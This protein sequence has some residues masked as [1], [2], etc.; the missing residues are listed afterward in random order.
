MSPPPLIKG[1]GR[2]GSLGEEGEYHIRCCE[3]YNNVLLLYMAKKVRSGREVGCDT[4]CF[5]DES[6]AKIQRSR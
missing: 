6:A 4:R 2:R 1:W 3:M 5:I